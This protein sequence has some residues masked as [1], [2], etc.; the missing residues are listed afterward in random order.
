M[1]CFVEL[2]QFVCFFFCLDSFYGLCRLTKN[3]LAELADLSC[4]F[5]HNHLTTS[6]GLLFASDVNTILLECHSKFCGTII[7]GCFVVLS[8]LLISF[9]PVPSKMISNRVWL[10]NLWRLLL[11]QTLFSVA[12]ST[13]THLLSDPRDSL[14]IALVLP[15]WWFLCSFS[16]SVLRIQSSCGL[17]EP[18]WRSAG[19]VAVGVPPVQ[20]VFLSPP[21][22]RACSLR[23]KRVCASSPLSLPLGSGGSRPT[24]DMRQASPNSQAN[25]SLHDDVDFLPWEKAACGKEH[26]LC[27]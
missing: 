18:G 9:L 25:T 4:V 20:H 7:S 16:S 23:I 24:T 27:D 11:N 22:P 2:C 26:P 17:G 5:N 6:L 1:F 12:T 8:F 13:T 10:E 3:K 14:R 15:L 19:L 21:S